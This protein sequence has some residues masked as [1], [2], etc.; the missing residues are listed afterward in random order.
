MRA[1]PHIIAFGQARGNLELPCRYRLSRF[2]T[3]VQNKSNPTAFCSFEVFG[4][5]FISDKGKYFAAGV[6]ISIAVSDSL[7]QVF[8]QADVVKFEISSVS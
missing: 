1:D 4:F 3:P 2:A 7:N 6:E 5:N 8:K